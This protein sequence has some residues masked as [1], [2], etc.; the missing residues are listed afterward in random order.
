MVAVCGRWW[1]NELAVGVQVR[2]G[3]CTLTTRILLGN[4]A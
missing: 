4:G 3:T 1:L 2:G